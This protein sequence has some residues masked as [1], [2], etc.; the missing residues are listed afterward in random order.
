MG[1][2]GWTRWAPEQDLSWFWG[3]IFESFLNTE[4]WNFNFFVG[5]FPV[6]FCIGFWLE[7]WTPGAIKSR[8]LYG[9]YC[10]NNFSHKLEFW[11]FFIQFLCFEMSLGTLFMNLGTSEG[12]LQFHGFSGLPGGGAWVEATYIDDASWAVF[13]PYS[14]HKHGDQTSNITYRNI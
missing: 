9:N 12:S 11:R 7:I 2:V 8:F 1:A 14:K 13:G 6:T 4:A 3:P 10:R 5:L